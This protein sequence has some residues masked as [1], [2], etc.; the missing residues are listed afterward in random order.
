E[1]SEERHTQRV[2]YTPEL[3]KLCNA[4]KLKLKAIYS[5]EKNHNLLGKNVEKLDKNFFRLFFVLQKER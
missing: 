3:I 2:Y 1:L 5:P 4:S